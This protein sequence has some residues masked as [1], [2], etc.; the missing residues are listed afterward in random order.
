M[1][2]SILSLSLLFLIII[3][4]SSV[5]FHHPESTDYLT[6]T[7]NAKTEQLRMYCK[8]D[9]GKMLRSLGQLQQHISQ[10]GNTLLLAM[11][12]GM[13]HADGSPVGLYV[14]EGKRLH[15]VNRRRCSSAAKTNWC[16]SPNGVF[17][18]TREGK[19]GIQATDKF[20]ET[21]A[22][23]YATQS[24]PILIANGKINPRLSNATKSLHIRNAIG[25]K[26]NGAVVMVISRRAVHF[27][28]LCQY[29]Q[30]QGCVDAL[31]LDGGISQVYCP[32]LNAQARGG[33]FGV[34]LAVV[35]K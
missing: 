33:D 21:E 28:E 7:V 10:H 15:P 6:Y 18:I 22:I 2:Y 29:M 31:Y 12:A 17:Y 1:K 27:Q 19:S 32:S 23:W 24:G 4:F 13:Y 30:Q 26:K 14:E 34:M 16:I 35:K 5:S 8:D 20:Q 3:A 25:V 9:K 11:N